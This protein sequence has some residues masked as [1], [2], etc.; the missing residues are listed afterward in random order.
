MRIPYMRVIQLVDK[1]GPSGGVPSLV[2]DLC[3]ALKD[4]GCDITLIGILNN[5]S[6]KKAPYSELKAAGIEVIELNASSKK[7]QFSAIFQS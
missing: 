5:K 3:F 4:A 2:Y 7:M 6:D 1:L